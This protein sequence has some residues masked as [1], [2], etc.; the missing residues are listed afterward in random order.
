MP[1]P[2]PIASRP[3]AAARFEAL[4]R[5]IARPAPDAALPVRTLIGAVIA[6]GAI[7][8]AVMGTYRIGAAGRWPLVVFSAVKVP[9]LIL[10]TTAVCLPA[11]FVLN[12]VAGLRD[13]FGRAVRAVLSGQAAMALALASLAPFTRFAYENDISH[14]AAQL[15][16]A[17]MFTVATAVGQAIMLRHYRAIIAS[18]WSAEDRHRLMLWAWIV[19]YVFTGIQTG[20]ILRPYIGVPGLDVRFFR[21]DAFTN[22]YMYFLRVVFGP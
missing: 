1:G 15:F 6:G 22:A 7:F 4:C 19:M 16:N 2:Q 5:A 11:F 8:G 10:V 3:G 21:A 14:P 20:W 17:A 9:A 18:N 12:T 13:D